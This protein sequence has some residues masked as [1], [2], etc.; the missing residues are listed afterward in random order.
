[1]LTG[2]D[3][4]LLYQLRVEKKRNRGPILPNGFLLG[5]LAVFNMAPQPAIQPLGSKERSLFSQVVKNYENKQYKKG[6]LVSIP[7]S[8]TLLSNMNRSEG[9][10]P[11]FTEISRPWRHDCHESAHHQFPGSLGGSV[12]AGE[13]CSP[14][15]QDAITCLLARFWSSLAVS[16][17]L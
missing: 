9:S 5:F 13:D 10:G 17:E 8:R 16:K 6:Y 12:H 15:V 11:D 1:M 2:S 14:E 4:L 7:S 3:S